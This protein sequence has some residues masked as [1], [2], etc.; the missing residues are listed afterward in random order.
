MFIF[1][2]L[3]LHEFCSPKSQFA[4]VNVCVLSMYYHALLMYF[5]Q[6]REGSLTAKFHY[7]QISDHRQR[8][9]GN[10][11]ESSRIH[12]IRPQTPRIM[13]NS[14]HLF[15]HYILCF[16]Y[17]PWQRTLRNSSELCKFHAVR[18][19]HPRI[20]RNSHHLL[21]PYTL[22]FRCLTTGRELTKI[23]ANQAK[24]AQFA[25]TSRE[26]R[27]LCTFAQKFIHN[28]VHY[29]QNHLQRT[30]GNWSES[31]RFHTVCPQLL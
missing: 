28:L 5:P 31:T 18:P 17:L 4:M 9:P 2:V 13:L 1:N 30:P 24:F 29:F 3:P 27:E 15:T 6:K 23:P 21:T 14:H 11:S 12:S 10:W 19:K 20:M 7:F 25:H 22:C 16:R 8:T 26:L